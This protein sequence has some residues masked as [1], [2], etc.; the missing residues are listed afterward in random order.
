MREMVGEI[1]DKKEIS[2]EEEN[3]KN[4]AEDNFAVEVIEFR[5]NDVH[6][7][8]DDQE[9]TAYATADCVDKPKDEEVLIKTT[10]SFISEMFIMF[11][12]HYLFSCMVFKANDG[13]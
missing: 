7:E 11:C 6:K 8:G 10:W 1:I 3:G 12:Y 2:S 4:I 9:E 5:Y 13:L